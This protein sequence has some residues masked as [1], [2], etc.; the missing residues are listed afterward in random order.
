MAPLDI[1][2]HVNTTGL[3]FIH[4]V[5]GLAFGAILEMAGFGNAN[6]LAAQ[7][8]FRNLTVLKVM[9]TAIITAMCGIFLTSGLSFLDYTQIWVNPTYMIPGIVGG[10]IMG[11]GFVIGGYCPGTSL[12]SMV[13]GKLDGL[14]FV[15]GVLIGIFA[16]GETVDSYVIWWNSTYMGRYTLFEW[17]DIPAGWVVVGVMLMALAMFKGGELLE[18]K[19]GLKR[20]HKPRLPIWA[21]GGFLLTALI[22]A[23][24]GQPDFEQRWQK[25]KPEKK[26]ALTKRQIFIEP[27]ELLSMLYDDALYI[28]IVDLRSEKDFNLFHLV[29]SKRWDPKQIT[30]KFVLDMR[31]TPANEVIVLLDNNET[32]GPQIWRYL[33]AYQVPNVYILEGGLQNW[34]QTFSKLHNF[35][36]TTN[37]SSQSLGYQINRAL[38]DRHQVSFPQ[39]ATLQGM[40]WENRVKLELKKAISGGGCG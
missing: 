34:L 29:N 32:N 15:L 33:T 7:F 4:F 27:A 16:F 26:E 35:E 30:E 39:K 11:V 5:L 1:L 6:L 25:V 38:G 17:L 31:S 13:T 19:F 20:E 21:L 2:E 24:V 10:L 9:F 36:P 22:I 3:Y 28:N 12:V 40:E 37:S 8:Y 23:L 14:F 18:Q